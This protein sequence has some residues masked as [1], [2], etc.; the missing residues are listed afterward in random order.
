M[1]V[2]AYASNSAFV[3]VNIKKHFRLFFLSK[4]PYFNF[5]FF[6]SLPALRWFL[7][8]SEIYGRSLSVVKVGGH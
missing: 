3:A 8:R 7:L 6:T 5:I 4:R 2:S 1:S